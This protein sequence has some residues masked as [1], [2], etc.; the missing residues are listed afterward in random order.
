[1]I[2]HYILGNTNAKADFQQ[3]ADGQTD[4]VQQSTDV[5]GVLQGNGNFIFI[6]DTSIYRK[7]VLTSNNGDFIKSGFLALPAT[8]WNDSS[9]WGL[10]YYRVINFTGYPG[11]NISLVYSICGLFRW[12]LR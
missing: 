9:S 1:M 7:M 2:F 4:W 6:H 3:S 10:Y 5:F 11:E 12:W 8:N